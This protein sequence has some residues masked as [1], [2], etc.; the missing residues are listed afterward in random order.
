MQSNLSRKEAY[1]KTEVLVL[2]QEE[3]EEGIGQMGYEETSEVIEMFVFWI[4]VMI[5]VV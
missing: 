3:E 5:S 4:V 2:V 1:L